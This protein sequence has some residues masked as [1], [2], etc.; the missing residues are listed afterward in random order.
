MRIAVIGVLFTSGA[1][2]ALFAD[3]CEGVSSS[4]TRP[5]VG[6]RAGGAC[7]VLGCVA[8]VSSPVGCAGT[9]ESVSV[10]V[11]GASIAAGGFITL[12]LAGMAGLALP[13]I[14]ALAVEVVHQVN[15]AAAV[16][17]GIVTALIDIEVAESTLPAVRTEALE[18]VH[19]VDAG[20][21]V[22][23]GRAD[24][25]VDVLMT[26][27]SA[28]TWITGAGEVA[29]WLADAA[30]SGS[31][32]VGGNVL[33]ASGV[34]GGYRDGA[35]VNHLT[36]GGQAVFLQTLTCLS[37]EAFGTGAV[38]VLPHAVTRG[39]VLTRVWVTSV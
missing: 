6:T 15:A 16:L 3:A 30:S 13:V 28:E 29:R 12:T 24:A 33:H 1:L 8:S 25:V 19:A 18:R 14:G 7:A 36:W 37:L 11:A 27:D 4:H 10:V 9:A 5:T 34:V 32:D 31:A 20:A 22:L 2:P 21:S 26:V 35:A 17:A 39:L 23:T 38:E